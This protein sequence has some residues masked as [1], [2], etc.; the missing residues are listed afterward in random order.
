MSEERYPQHLTGVRLPSFSNCVKK[1]PILNL[2]PKLTFLTKYIF[3]KSLNQS[4]NEILDK[5]IP[6][7]T[8][9]DNH[10]Y[11]FRLILSRSNQTIRLFKKSPDFFYFKPE[12]RFVLGHQSIN[13]LSSPE[14]YRYSSV[15][16]FW[17]FKQK[18]A[19]WLGSRIFYQQS[20]HNNYSVSIISHNYFMIP[21][22]TGR[23]NTETFH[24]LKPRN[25]KVEN[26]LHMHHAESVKVIKTSTIYE[27]FIELKFTF[28][29]IFLKVV[30]AYV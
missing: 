8:P 11:F 2:K 6:K 28:R 9:C 13:E 20:R 23:E 3:P 24:M 17:W 30:E 27:K 14:E 16:P 18:A 25:G 4:K 21:R 12:M 7:R 5:C 19:R 1:S 22:H 15:K 26:H 10:F 29:K